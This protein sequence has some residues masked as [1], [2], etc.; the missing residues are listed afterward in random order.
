[1]LESAPRGEDESEVVAEAR[2]RPVEHL[3]AGGAGRGNHPCEGIVGSACA[4]RQHGD[5]ERGSE[6]GRPEDECFEAAAGAGDPLGFDEPA[7]RLDLR[8]ES[9]PGRKQFGRGGHVLGRLDLGEYDHVRVRLRRG[10]QVV[11]PPRCR[12]SVDAECR[13]SGERAASQRGDRNPARGLLV[14]G[15]D[16]ILEVDDHLVGGE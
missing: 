12:T 5:A 4:D 14:L 16:R 11:L 15:R 9:D 7:C 13:R 6:I 10:A 2:V 8:L 1:M 3:Q